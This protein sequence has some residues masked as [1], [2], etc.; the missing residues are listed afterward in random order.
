[1]T[2]PAGTMACFNAVNVSDDMLNVISLL[3]ND[4]LEGNM[5]TVIQ[6]LASQLTKT[7]TDIRNNALDMLQCFLM[8]KYRLEISCVNKGIGRPTIDYQSILNICMALLKD[9]QEDGS[10]VLKVTNVL[11]QTLLLMDFNSFCSYAETI[12]LQSKLHLESFVSNKYLEEN[13]SHLN[14]NA[15]VNIQILGIVLSVLLM[16]EKYLGSHL[17]TDVVVS[18]LLCCDDMQNLLLR[19]IMCNIGHISEDTL[20][21]VIPKFIQYNKNDFLQHLWKHLMKSIETKEDSQLSHV[22]QVL[23]TVA[24]FYLPVKTH[25]S[26][27]V[28]VEND[29]W[30]LLQNGLIERN[31]FIRKQA[32]YLMKRA[33]HILNS[34]KNV[35]KLQCSDPVFWWDISSSNTI[36][37][38]F[39]LIIETLEEKQ[40]HI[41]K[42]VL[43][44]LNSLVDHCLSPNDNGF[45]LHKSWILCVLTR[46]INH[47]NV[48][49]VKWGISNF[50]QSFKKLQFLKC[51]IANFLG[52][53]F[54]AINNSSLYVRNST[55]DAS[56][57]VV[58]QLQFLFQSAAEFPD[59]DCQLFFNCV[60]D[61]IIEIS[62]APV[63]LFYVTYAL[64]STPCISVWNNEKLKLVKNFI[65][66]ALRCQ[67]VFIRSAVQ[68]LFLDATIHLALKSLNIFVVADLLGSFRGDES[69]KRG[70]CEWFTS[71]E[72][73]KRI[74]NKDDAVKF[75]SITLSGSESGT[76]HMIDLSKKSVARF[77]LLLCD[78]ELLPYFVNNEACSLAKSLRII[79]SPFQNCEKRTYAD[80]KI[81]DNSLEM[82]NNLL[83]ESQILNPDAVKVDIIRKT[84]LDCVDSMLDQIFAWFNKKML[85]VSHLQDYHQVNICIATLETFTVNLEALPHV[86][87]NVSKLQETAENVAATAN[88]PPICRYFSLK[89][90]AITSCC[91]TRY[92]KC[93]CSNGSCTL[94]SKLENMV[95]NIVTDGNLNRTPVKKESDSHLTRDLQTLWG[96]LTSEYLEAKWSIVGNF[97][98]SCRSS[99]DVV[100]NLRSSEFIVGDAAIAL[101]IGG[102]NVLVP[103]MKVVEKILPKC[104]DS[105]N[106]LKLIST[107][108]NL[109][110]ELRKT[111][112]FWT[113]MRAFI[114]VVFQPFTMTAVEYQ[115]YLLQYAEKIF[116][117]GQTIGG[118]CNLLIS[119]LQCIITDTSVNLLDQKWEILINALIFGPV[120]RKDQRIITE[121]CQYIASLGHKCATN[122][123]IPND[124]YADSEVRM[125]GL[126]LVLNIC[127][128]SKNQNIANKLMYALIEKEQLVSDGKVR[129]YNDS[130]LHR[131]KNRILQNLLVLE[132]LVD[133]EAVEKLLAWLRE[134]MLKESQ[135]PSIRYQQEWLII[136][137]LLHHPSLKENLWA[138]FEE[139]RIMLTLERVELILLC[140]DYHRTYREAAD[141]FLRWHPDIPKTSPQTVYTM[142]NKFKVTGTIADSK[143][144]CQPK[145]ST[146]DDRWANVIVNVITAQEKRPGSICS[147]IAIMYHLAT[148]LTD[149]TEEE[150]IDR[151]IQEI[152]PLCMAQHFSIRLYAQ[153][154]F[155]RGLGKEKMPVLRFIDLCCNVMTE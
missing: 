99:L 12:A 85:S 86:A 98:H 117:Q 108:W 122:I 133:T 58:K 14:Y 25:I 101:E 72:W 82:V 88:A 34:E 75:I 61:N 6:G 119:H 11:E 48:G 111:E 102:R 74:F 50:V 71:C 55:N 124:C 142:M 121:A 125:R 49:I 89:S 147:F 9:K 10:C 138:M 1:M 30:K 152:L 57:D 81:L 84:I 78:A 104:M 63:P 70:T 42:P 43:P 46:I 59:D 149:G 5:N 113:A 77:I 35:I 13:I 103:V 139:V 96:K 31:P 20:L 51:C 52:T 80:G 69:L 17:F 127:T 36:W 136:R 73:L 143:R 33:V 129:Y 112:L 7:D 21:Y 15:N 37:E 64:A 132:P 65:I 56:S 22:F 24:E 106:T 16:K 4:K 134:S 131:I 47:D 40:V 130:H 150:F 79:L 128:G 54:T 60:L 109:T 141:E 90:L 67:D 68:C 2:E 39:F 151:S 62:W 41:I 95:R 115:N 144:S 146:N 118:L 8:T 32:L 87:A 26:H 3:G 53:F 116:Q 38:Q 97:L 19:L 44:V 105:E 137:I 83:K 153:T 91:L 27:N 135:Q 114:C 66:E 154:P 107:F 155:V 28:T 110:F 145:T 148:A 23:C 76:E 100:L 45:M 94:I 140:G 18:N 123:L 93:K 29:F 92:S 120:H 126:E